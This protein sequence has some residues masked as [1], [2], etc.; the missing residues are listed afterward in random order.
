MK[1]KYMT[2]E[3]K[4]EIKRM[5]AWLDRLADKCDKDEHAEISQELWGASSHLNMAIYN[6]RFHYDSQ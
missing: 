5:S 1:S 4:K 2:K 3:V 6:D